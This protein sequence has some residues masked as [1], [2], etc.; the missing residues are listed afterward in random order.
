MVEGL[1]SVDGRKVSIVLCT[2]VGFGVFWFV[3]GKYGFWW[4]VLY[5]VFWETWLGYRLAEWLLR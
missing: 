3:W 4:G 5:G 2:G 1:M